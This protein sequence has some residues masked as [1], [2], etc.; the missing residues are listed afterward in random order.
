MISCFHTLGDILLS[1]AVLRR[2]LRAI[3]FW[4][5]TFVYNRIHGVI[6]IFHV[7]VVTAIQK[8]VAFFLFIIGVTVDVDNF[9]CLASFVH[10]LCGIDYY[11]YYWCTRHS[12]K[13]LLIFFSQH[14]ARLLYIMFAVSFWLF[15]SNALC[16]QYYVFFV[17]HILNLR[18][19]VVLMFDM[20]LYYNDMFEM[21]I[22]SDT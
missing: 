20:N 3:F 9:W 5:G 15:V 10:I 18:Y 12:W 14:F 19:I 4:Y 13:M 16:G 2:W 11:Y 21:L 22:H 6:L 17:Y 1:N 7:I 8:F